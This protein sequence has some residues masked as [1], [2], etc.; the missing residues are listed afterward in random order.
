MLY[1]TRPIR[2]TE[3]E[4]IAMQIVCKTY[5]DKKRERSGFDQCPHNLKASRPEQKTKYLC[6]KFLIMSSKF[7]VIALDVPTARYGKLGKL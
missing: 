6:T 3:N 1:S 7:S 2:S 4:N 5:S